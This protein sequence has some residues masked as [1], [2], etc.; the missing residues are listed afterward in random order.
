M[1]DD[2]YHMSDEHM[3]AIADH[4]VVK[5]AYETAFKEW[6]AASSALAVQ[7]QR[8]ACMLGVGA[9]AVQAQNKYL[10]LMSNLTEQ[11]AE[12]TRRLAQSFRADL[13]NLTE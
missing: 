9:K 7:L 12:D 13:D 5:L 4:Q 6:Q 11:F 1:P 3:E 8:S 2:E 10:G